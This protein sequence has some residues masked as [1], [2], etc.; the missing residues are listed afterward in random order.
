MLCSTTS[1]QVPTSASTATHSTGR[2]ARESA[3]TPALAPTEAATLAAMVRRARRPSRT[4]AGTRSTSPDMSAAWLVSTAAADPDRPMDTPTSAAASAG[5]SFMPSP[6]ISVG[7]A[8]ALRSPTRRTLSSG[9][10]PAWSSSRTPPSCSCARFA[11]AAL[12]P[13][14]STDLMPMDRSCLI[15]SAAPVRQSSESEKTPTR[16]PSQITWPVVDTPSLLLRPASSE[17]AQFN[18]VPDH[19]ERAD[20]EL[21]SGDGPGL[22]ERGDP[23]LAQRLKNA[24]SLDEQP[25][26][27]LPEERAEGG[28]RR[29]EHQRARARAHQQHQGQPEPVLQVTSSQQQ[30]HEH[31]PGSKNHHGCKRS[32][33]L[34]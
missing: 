6:T 26:P 29:R 13:V 33:V 10:S 27:G 8:R 23:D 22:V 4:A 9:R 15:A 21:P 11:A 25:H 19:T 17:L 32:T 28:D 16:S 24:A 1:R 7:P 2:H 12:S 18:L 34:G 5:A 14:R 31:H 20:A 3:R 30:W